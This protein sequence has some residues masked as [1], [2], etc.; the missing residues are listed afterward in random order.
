MGGGLG[1]L[2]SCQPE[3]PQQ[4]TKYTVTL[5]STS[6][7]TL[8]GIKAEGYAAG[9][10]VSFTVT[11]K[12]SAKEVD[13]VK[14]GEQ[15]LTPTNGTYSFNM[16][17]ANVTISVT[18]R[19]KVVPTYQVSVAASDDFSV[20]GLKA[21]GYKEGE[22]V[23][24]TIT[25]LNPDKVID[26]VSAVGAAL[27]PNAE[28]V[29][30]FAM[31]AGNVEIVVTLKNA[32]ATIG[33][34]GSQTSPYIIDNRVKFLS[35]GDKIADGTLS[36]SGYYLLDV[37]VDITGKEW[38]PIGTFDKPFSGV[39]DGGGHSITGLSITEFSEMSLETQAY[40]F[41]GMFGVTD[42]ASIRDFDLVDFSVEQ[43]VYGRDSLFYL[44]GVAG[45]GMNTYVSGVNVDFATFD[46]T[47]IQTGNSA[48]YIGGLF[49]SLWSIEQE[50]ADGSTVSTYLD[51]AK[52]SVVGD[53]NFD[54]ADSEGVISYVGG[55]VG[56]TYTAYRNVISIDNAFYRGNILGGT[57]IGGIA[58]YLDLYGS[59]VDTYAI[60]ESL[61]S[62]DAGGSYVGGIVGGTSYETLIINSYANY[63]TL[64]APESSGY[65][66]SYAGEIVG[67][68]YED[69]YA[70]GSNYNGTG[71]A[72]SFFKEGAT[73]TA[74][75]KTVKGTS[76]N[77]E[78]SLFEEKLNFNA[79]IWEFSGETPSIKRDGEVGEVQVTLKSNVDGIADKSL[80]ANG[81]TYDVEFVQSV[82]GTSFEKAN[83]SFNG[84]TY[85]EAGEVAY[86]WYAPIDNDTTLF[87]KFTDLTPLLGDYTY[88]CM[89]YDRETGSG[90]YKFTED[91]FYWIS[92][93]HQ[94]M[95]YEYQLLDNYILI[96]DGVPAADGEFYGGYEG[97]IFFLNEDGTITGYDVNDQDAVYTG[98][99]TTTE[100]VI[101]D[102]TGHAALGTWHIGDDIINL[103]SDGLA[104]GRPADRNY[105]S[106]G[107]FVINGDQ[108]EIVIFSIVNETF[109]YDAENDLLIGSK[110]SLGTRSEVTASYGTVD[111]S[112]K[113]Y[114]VGDKTYVLSAGAVADYTV[115]G[116]LA[117]GNHVTI[118]GV[119]YVVTGA[120]LE[121]YEEPVEPEPEPSEEGFVGTRKG[122]V[123]L[124]D[125]E[126]VL[127]EDG[128]GTYGGT[129]F[130]YK[131]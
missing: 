38:T 130:T 109:T 131:Q 62:Q 32:D 94:V 127:N 105:D 107:G 86:R 68:T 120:T 72:N 97:S 89:Y 91:Y 95:T 57:Y 9:E 101:P 20:S 24:F 84:F 23:D 1:F 76:I 87:S 73:V 112:I 36:A 46:V 40:N 45:L 51:L 12:D 16:G 70:E 111:G 121:V 41:G 26:S 123:G 108:V 106:F 92:D 122:K 104:L 69:G 25:L 116:E 27:T 35:L 42:G 118:N 3:Q 64:T 61:V 63:K 2:T 114:V 52:S 18:L 74:N 14:A 44:G 54:A 80:T 102:Y 99:R 49:G 103:F 100:V 113:V 126:I 128:T 47:S 29:Y 55:L 39:F 93:D 30:S 7:V 6:E 48:F 110:N 60:G 56:E 77:D 119:E 82:M 22:M 129:D 33:G 67:L 71:V 15:V 75:N 19:D 58:G 115:E 66:A 50:L 65:Y 5:D 83:H 8:N 17:T 98:T 53:I 11:P 34:D 78:T 88:V 59:I 124:N 21:E 37:D 81:G 43:V 96:G 90:H 125:T 117:E 85:D 13:V 10:T 4:V 31:P 28:G 79:D